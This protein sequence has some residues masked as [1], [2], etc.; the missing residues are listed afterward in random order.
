LS[1]SFLLFFLRLEYNTVVNIE[2]SASRDM[3]LC[4]LKSWHQTKGVTLQK[5]VLLFIACSNLHICSPNLENR[6]PAS[7]TKQCTFGTTYV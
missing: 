5:S 6:F 2:T 1:G 3:A 4:N 7:K